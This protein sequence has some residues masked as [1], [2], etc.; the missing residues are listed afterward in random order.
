MLVYIS[1]GSDSQELV[2]LSCVQFQ[3]EGVFGGDAEVLAVVL[4]E[5]VV[6][7]IVEDEV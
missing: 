3:S 2:S 6:V 7:D 5:L 1:D 4:F